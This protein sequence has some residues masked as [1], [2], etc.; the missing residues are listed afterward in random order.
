MCIQCQ[1][2]FNTEEEQITHINNYCPC[3]K[4]YRR[5]TFP[6]EVSLKFKNYQIH[7]ES[8]ERLFHHLLSS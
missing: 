4:D 1:S 6:D 5:V 8:L 2:K 3:N 7:Q